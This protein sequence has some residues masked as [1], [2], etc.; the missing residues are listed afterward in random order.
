MPL[1]SAPCVVE[2]SMAMRHVVMES[3]IGIDDAGAAVAVGDDLGID[4]ERFGEV[5][6]H[7]R[8]GGAD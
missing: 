4:V 6:A 1:P 2:A 8:G 7:V 3:A 5:G